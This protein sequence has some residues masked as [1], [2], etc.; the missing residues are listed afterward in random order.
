M[1]DAQ[2]SASIVRRLALAVFLEWLGSTAVL[3]LLPL[4]LRNKGA[5]PGVTGVVMSAYFFAGVLLQYVAG[6]LCDRFGRRP[7]L[8]CGLGCYALACVGFLLPL[9]PLAY[10]LLRFAQGGSAGAVE[11]ATLATIAL[12]VPAEQRGRASSRIYSA[13]LGAAAIG[14]LLGAFVGV[15]DMGV[16]FVFAGCAAVAAALP[17]LR[18]DLGPRHTE[19]GTALGRVTFDARLLGAMSAAVAIGLVIGAYESCWTLL[20]HFRHASSFQLGLSW[21]LFALPYVVCFRMGGWAADNTDRRVSTVVGVVNSCVFCA[22]YPL[23]G[24]VDVLLAFSCFE[25]IGSSLALPA[26]QSM[27]TEGADPT[28]VGRRQGLFATSQ[29]AA[30][31]VS[32]AVS[33][34]LFDVGPAVPF[35]TMAAIGTALGLLAPL[36][37]RRV[38]GR[39]ARDAIGQTP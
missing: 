20:L 16:I 12:V 29:T 10:G 17:V 27:L 19:A 21:T 25:A 23:I 15:S 6:R 4:Y 35:L 1:V 38:P 34:A 33:G 18:S 3:P 26:A 28:E 9:S 8:V 31:A 30:M 39:V 2:R 7:V 32:A 13:Q 5:T 37:W 24:T 11:V 14:P 22:I 36:W